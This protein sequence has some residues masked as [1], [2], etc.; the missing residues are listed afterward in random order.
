MRSLNVTRFRF[1]LA[2]PRL[3]PAGRGG[4]P[5]A[6]G[7]LFYSTLIDALLAAGIEP[8]VTLYHWDLP[9]ALQDEYGGW[10]S[11]RVVADFR[12]YA[13]AAFALFGTRV[14]RWTTLNEPWVFTMQGYQLGT[15]AP[16]LKGQGWAAAKNAV[17]AHA[18]AASEF[19]ALVPHGRLSVNINGDW[20]QPWSSD[21]DDV[22]AAGRALD[23]G[24]HLF[25]DPLFFGQWVREQE[26]EGG[27]VVAAQCSGSDLS[28]SPSQPRTALAAGAT[29]FTAAESAALLAATP[30][31]FALNFYTAAY[32]RA[33]PGGVDGGTG[34]VAGFERAQASG[35]DGAPI[36]PRA[37][38]TWLY[39]TPWA[40]RAMLNHVHARYGAPEIVVTENG[41]SAPGERAGAP[42]AAAV[43]DD[44]R[45][46]YYASYLREAAAAVR[47]DGV[48]R[49]R[50]GAGA[51]RRGAS[52]SHLFFFSPLHQ[53][54]TT[55]F[56]WSLLDNFAWADGYDAL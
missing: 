35:P 30:D 5:N 10:A 48:V 43:A 50:A 3:F 14:A 1:S 25:G 46:D 39:K 33:A 34:A 53:P 21:A 41:C 40:F 23:L 49:R 32:V 17:L 29:P 44:W 24:L 37:A 9:Q 8:W 16:G 45:V 42:K 13:A 56:A 55:Y 47:Q 52:A 51:R 36:G 7:V 26:R 19:R 38:S 6:D 27:G 2:W 22:V 31:H 54:L 11:E 20:A 4:A 12:A 18:A 28:P 15:H